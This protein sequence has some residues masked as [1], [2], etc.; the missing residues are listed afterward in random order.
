MFDEYFYDYR[1]LIW[2]KNC[3]LV[4]LITSHIVLMIFQKLPFPPTH[5]LATVKQQ[6]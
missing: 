3:V 1:K 2:G 6:Q 4:T 5:T